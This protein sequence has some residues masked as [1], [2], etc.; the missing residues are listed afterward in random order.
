MP[1]HP[2][3]AWADHVHGPA[4]VLDPVAAVAQLTQLHTAFP[5][6]RIWYATKCNPHPALLSALAGAGAGFEVAS[7]AEIDLLAGLGVHPRDMPFTHP[8]RQVG[9]VSGALA[10][11]VRTWTVDSVGEVDKIARV[12]RGLGVDTTTLSLALR[13]DVPACAAAHPLRGKFGADLSDVPAIAAAAGRWG[14]AVTTVAFHVGSQTRDPGAWAPA[15]A[16]AADA[17]ALLDRDQLQVLN[18]GGGFPATYSRATRPPAD[19]ADAVHQAVAD[20]P[21]LAGLTVGLEPGRF[22]AAPAAHVVQVVTAVAHRG[23]KRWVHTD[24]GVYNGLLEA[25]V[26]RGA[27]DLPVTYAG[28]GRPVAPA[29]LA[30]PTC[31]TLDVV[32]TCVDLPV[33]LAPGERLV[34]GDAGAYTYGLATT[35]NGFTAPPVLV[36]GVDLPA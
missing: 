30:G 3:P 9:E 11:G 8:V 24:V 13:L 21:V 15:V 34:V 29:V 20:H 2:L 10:R 33:D 32:R 12:A 23:G 1:D 22:I 17:C 5:G 16:R 14:M 35:F 27:E 19:F 25:W 31:D 6:A 4:I 28:A 36:R 26:L 7:V 18:I